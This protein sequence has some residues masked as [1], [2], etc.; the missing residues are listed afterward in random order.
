MTAPTP[1]QPLARPPGGRGRK[2]LG[3]KVIVPTLALAFA[4]LMAP[5]AAAASSSGLDAEAVEPGSNQDNAPTLQPGAL[6]TS[7]F[8]SETSYYRV[9]R[10]MEDSTLHVGISTHTHQGD[11]SDEAQIELGTLQG[12]SCDDE[13]LGFSGSVPSTLFRT[14]QVS[15]IAPLDP[16]HHSAVPECGEAEELLLA[17]S[18]SAD[19]IVGHDYELIIG[20][21]PDPLNADELRESFD[22]ED[23]DAEAA[24]QN[25]QR[26]RDAQNTIEPGT[27]LADAPALE[28]AATYDAALQPG[29]VHIYRMD[30]G[31]NQLIQAEA[32][33]PEPSS[34]L[35]EN[36][37]GR[38]EARLDIIGPHRGQAVPTGHRAAGEQNS[39]DRINDSSATTLAAATYPVLWNGR[40]SEWPS[41]INAQHTSLSG[42]YFIMVSAQP[43]DEGEDPFEIPYRLTADTFA[44]TDAEEPI[45][46]ESLL[47]PGSSP[48]GQDG[49]AGE[50]SSDPQ[51]QE[52]A[53]AGERTGGISLASGIAMSLGAF[54][55]LLIAAGGLFLLRLSRQNR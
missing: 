31:W 5:S 39:S 45:Y 34:E 8:G 46:A 13:R 26:D 23:W 54:G 43:Q 29:D 9:A 18:A 49:S 35:S 1:T 24:W 30:A 33:F 19:D 14:A 10:T 25:L 47:Q 52:E 44:V 22:D 15:A 41:G 48:A 37:G 40:Y 11:H 6:Y 17:V 55:L 42:D 53:L 2:P 7:T 21:E 12:A 28:K 20:E 3:T 50:D 4:A 27:V 51:D 36:L 32:F 16:D 38:Q